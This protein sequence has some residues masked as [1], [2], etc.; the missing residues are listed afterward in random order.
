MKD[1]EKWKQLP[2]MDEIAKRGKRRNKLSTSHLPNSQDDPYNVD[3]EDDLPNPPSRNLPMGRDRS[4]KKA[5]TSS[6]SYA[7]SDE[8][9]E[10][11]NQFATM[12]AHIS[13]RNEFRAIELYM[14]D[15]S[16]LRAH[17]KQKWGFL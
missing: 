3:V 7:R 5:K 4:K 6:S 16:H 9:A 13:S 8:L 12:N 14:R 1:N 2:L 17:L 11:R 15:I 10:I